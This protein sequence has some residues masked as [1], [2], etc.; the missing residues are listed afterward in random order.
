MKT[1]DKN[2]SFFSL[3]EFGISAIDLKIHD[4]R[5]LTLKVHLIVRYNCTLKRIHLL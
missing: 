1:G 5:E 4:A 3:T 2:S